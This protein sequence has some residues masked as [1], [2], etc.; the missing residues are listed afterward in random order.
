MKPK[1]IVNCSTVLDYAEKATEDQLQIIKV[2]RT[3]NFGFIESVTERCNN[4]QY[5]ARSMA[6]AATES[7]ISKEELNCPIEMG[8]V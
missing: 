8:R 1:L 6:L 2:A 3:E 7:I 5:R 4:M